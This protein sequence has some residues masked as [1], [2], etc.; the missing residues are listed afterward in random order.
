[1][2]LPHLHGGCIVV[3][4]FPYSVYLLLHCHVFSVELCHEVR[5]TA[6]VSP[7]AVLLQLCNIVPAVAD[8]VLAA[9]NLRSD[10]VTL[11]AMT[12]APNSDNAFPSALLA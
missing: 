1:M 10:Q 12:N 8:G 11:V 2:L 5:V 4:R 6:A 7:S 3:A 9:A